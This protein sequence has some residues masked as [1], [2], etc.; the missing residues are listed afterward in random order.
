MQSDIQLIIWIIYICIHSDTP[1]YNSPKSSALHLEDFIFSS[2]FKM[3]LDTI[4]AISKRFSSFK[5]QKTSNFIE[6]VS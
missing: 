3:V 2:S 5:K 1:G 4:L 6:P